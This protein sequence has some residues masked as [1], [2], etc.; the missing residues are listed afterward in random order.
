MIGGGGKVGGGPPRPGLEPT[1]PADVSKRAA[2]GSP[3]TE[4]PGD[5]FERAK[6]AGPGPVDAQKLARESS[7]STDVLR[8]ARENPAA[9]RQLV[10]TMA[11]QTASNLSQIHQEMAGAR[12]VL[13]QMAAERFTKKAQDKHARDLKRRR[14]KLG[15]M[16]MRLHLGM[17]K[18]A[19]LQQLA[20]KLGDPRLEDELDRLLKHHDKLKTDWGRRHHLLD[21]ADTL[22]GA[23]AETPEHLR[24]V[25]RTD[26]RSGAQGEAIGNALH[27][28][29]PRRVIAELIARTIDGT[30]VEA[31]ESS[32]DIGQRGEH[33]STLQ[34]WA[35]VRDIMVA[36]LAEDPLKDDE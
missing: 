11:S 8:L 24:D 7:G 36:S 10:A 28:V 21:I 29:S 17:R 32:T 4:K 6:I 15:S 30:I 22:Y 27:D 23:D 35:A 31:G 14:D 5:R 2:D 9:A 16:K 12:A 18:M 25:V 26:I 34:S 1:G 13:E 19:L 20:G 33:G 3:L